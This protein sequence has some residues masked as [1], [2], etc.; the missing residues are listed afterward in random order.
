MRRFP[1][2]SMNLAQVGYDPVTA[3]L[4]VV[5]VSG[6]R[7]VYTYQHVGMI[8]FVKLITAPS[9]GQYFDKYIRSKSKLHPYTKRKE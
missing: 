5:F 9:I 2:R 4:E 3:T 7:W 6:S 1:V 8:K